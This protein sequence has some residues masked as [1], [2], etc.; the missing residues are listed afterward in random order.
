MAETDWQRLK[1]MSD[2]DIER[3]IAADPDA[4][5][6]D[7]PEFWRSAVLKPPISGMAL[8]PVESTL[9]DRLHAHHIDYVPMVNKMLRALV[10]A[11]ETN[12]QGQ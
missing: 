2:A 6:P 11:H 10:E 8:I 5:L 7:D 1:T 12:Q 9:P 4:Q 3:A